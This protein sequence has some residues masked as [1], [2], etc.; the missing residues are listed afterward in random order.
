[1]FL[2]PDSWPPFWT[3]CFSQYKYLGMIQ[4]IEY[5]ITT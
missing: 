1:M 2:R 3:I 5:L 4:E